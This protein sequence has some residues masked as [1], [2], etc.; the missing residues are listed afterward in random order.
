MRRKGLSRK[1]DSKMPSRSQDGLYEYHGSTVHLAIDSVKDLDNA[2]T[3][4][5]VHWL[6][7]TAPLSDFLLPAKFLNLLDEDDDGRIRVEEVKNAIRWLR[8][9]SKLETSTGE[10]QRSQLKS[11][12]LEEGWDKIARA[13]ELSES[14]PLTTTKLANFRTKYQENPVAWG[15]GSLVPEEVDDEEQRRLLSSIQQAVKPGIEA[16]TEEQLDQFLEDARIVVDWRNSSPGDDAWA[17][18]YPAYKVLGEKLQEYFLLA[19]AAHYTNKQPEFEW[20]KNLTDEELLSEFKKMPLVQP[21]RREALEFEDRPNPAYLEELAE[22]RHTFLKSGESALSRTQFWEMRSRFQTY[23]GWLDQAP[24]TEAT[25]LDT[26]TLETWL[27]DETLIAK[28]RQTLQAKRQSGLVLKD[29]DNL[30]KLMLLQEHLVDFCRNFVAFPDLYNPNERALFERGTLIMDGREFHLCLPVDDIASHKKAAARSNTFVLYIAVGKETL[31]VP[32]TSGSQGYLAT[33]KRGIFNHVDGKEKE[34]KVL[35]LVT[36]PISFYE[37]LIAPF[38]K[39]VQSLKDKVEKLSSDK[40]KDLVSG[41]MTPAQPSTSGGSQKGSMLA[42]GGLAIAAI[43]S[44]LAFVLKTLATLTISKIL[45]GFLSLFLAFFIPAALVAYIKLKNRDLSAILEGNTW[46]INARMKLTSAQAKQF[47]Q[48]PRHPGFVGG[49]VS[50][51]I[52]FGLLL[53]FLGLGYYYR[54]SLWILV[55][56]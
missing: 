10:F 35:D 25:K 43:G 39:I 44:S 22:F 12:E 18:Q 3:L 9:S 56:S 15:S 17:D 31:A 8:A 13:F 29:F 21:L 45:I 20:P 19:D 1:V 27:Q 2:L 48:S 5:E 52:G 16:V 14:E 40:E 50:R 23:S 41:T 33:E 47:T 4:D 7:S 30:E 36:N 51:W 42:G 34:A 54:E 32:V 55:A 6:A 24:S 53:G 37:A 38:Q 28:T 11:Q 46:G 26:S 49:V